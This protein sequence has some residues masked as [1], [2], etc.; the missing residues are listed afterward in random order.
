MHHNVYA[1]M[2]KMNSCSCIKKKNTMF[3]NVFF[4]FFCKTC[5][6]FFAA[7]FMHEH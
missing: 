2:F 1:S 5:C 3:Y 6:I 7:G 4:F